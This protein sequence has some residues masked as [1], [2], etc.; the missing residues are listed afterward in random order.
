MTI[1]D[2][3][4]Q[5][6]S[7]VTILEVVSF[8]GV[9]L[10]KKGEWFTGHCPFHD[11][12][13]KKPSFAVRP[14]KGRCGCFGCGKGGDVVDFVEQMENCNRITALETLEK[15]YLIQSTTEG[16]KVP[17]IA[18]KTAKDVDLLPMWLVEKSQ[19]K[20]DERKSVLFE[21]LSRV[22]GPDKTL[23][24]FEAYRVGTTKRQETI[25][26]Q[27]DKGG[28]VRAGKIMRYMEDDGHRD[29]DRKG[30]I[31]WVHTYKDE[32][33]KDLRKR[34]IISEDWTQTQCLFGEHLLTK[35]P[36]DVVGLVESE[37][38]ALVASICLPKYVWVSVG[39]AS[40][41]TPERAKPLENRKVLVFADLNKADE[42]EQRAEELRGK[43]YDVKLSQVFQ[44]LAT[45]EDRKKGHDIADVL[46]RYAKAHPFTDEALF[47]SMQRKNADLAEMAETLS[48]EVV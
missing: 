15:R 13:D 20:G 40:N 44:Q 33:G 16:A 17:Q 48:L 23:K 18:K 38:T 39:G 30:S 25:F 24:A 41:F 46:I 1:K 28:G 37:K 5:I 34:G 31:N 8:Y 21:F 3:I 9:E 22:Y 12:E 47:A 27:I 32:S 4:E 42:W 7:R 2:R 14:S 6:K 11:H 10:Q 19:E 45:D 43:G 26:W 29:K 36:L 35:R